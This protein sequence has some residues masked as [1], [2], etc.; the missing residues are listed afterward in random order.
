MHLHR[1]LAYY[2]KYPLSTFKLMVKLLY[3][4]SSS[5]STPKSMAQDLKEI[6]EII[7]RYDLG[8]H[9]NFEGL[10]LTKKKFNLDLFFNV[11]YPHLNGLH[12]TIPEVKYFYKSLKKRWKSLMFY[13]NNPLFLVNKKGIIA[14]GA[15]YFMNSCRIEKNDVVIDLGATPGDFGALAICSGA[16]KVYCFDK[17]IDSSIS[18]T[19][20]LNENKIEMISSYVSD[21]HHDGFST[22]LDIFAGKIGD[23]K[24]GFIKMDIE[25][26][27]IEAING[28]RKVIAAHHPKMAICVYHDYSHLKRIKRMIKST[29][30]HYKFET[31]GPVLYCIPVGNDFNRVQIKY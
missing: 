12:Y 31:I 5:D 19:A 16:K 7:R 8:T 21:I 23:E 25:G 1:P 4:I 9:Y 27:E 30:P 10:I 22:T 24:I 11:V 29:N 28:A 17:N 13:S 6:N 26:A 18:E 20:K 14:H 3:E 2:F 15:T